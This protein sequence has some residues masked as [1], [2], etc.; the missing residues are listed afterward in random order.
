MSKQAQSTITVSAPEKT[1]NTVES[2]LEATKT[3]AL[4]A[5]IT[6]IEKQYGVGSIMKMGKAQ[7]VGVK[8]YSSGSLSLDLAMGGGIPA[9]RIIEIFGPESSGKT[10]LA[11]HAIA[12]VQKNGGKA[13]FIDA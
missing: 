1:K 9:S 3:D 11:L 10:T 8:T 12:E 7:Q 6:E 5:A 4:K 2:K 13:A